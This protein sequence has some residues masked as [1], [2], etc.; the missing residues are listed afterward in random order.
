MKNIQNSTSIL[1]ILFSALFLGACEKHD[2]T[3]A[4]NI[5]AVELHLKGNGIDQVFKWEDTDGDGVANRIDTLVLPQM[6][7]NITCQVRIFDRSE[8]PEIELTSEIVAEGVDHLLTYGVS[9]TIGLQISGL[10]QDNNG[11]PLGT[12]SIWTTSNAGA[13]GTL[14]LTMYH[15]PTDKNSPTNPGGEVDFQVVFPARIQ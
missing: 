9:N 8:T 6:T 12:E 14:T 1:L 2:H 10:N 5:T 7:S 15:E 3:A 4:E 13:G 11:N